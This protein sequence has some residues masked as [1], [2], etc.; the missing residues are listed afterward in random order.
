[1]NRCPGPAVVL[2]VEVCKIS[3]EQDRAMTAIYWSSGI[4]FYW[5]INL[6]DGQVEVYSNPCPSRYQTLDVPAPPHVLPVVIDGVRV[7]EIAVTDLL[8]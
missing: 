6:I 4:L 5:I 1:L 8:P 2:I 7:G 3:L